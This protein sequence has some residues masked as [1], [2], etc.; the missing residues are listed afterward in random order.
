[1]DFCKALKSA[2]KK[3][4][5]IKR[6]SGKKKVVIVLDDEKTDFYMLFSC[7]CGRGLNLSFEDYT[8]DDW[9]TGILNNKEKETI[10]LVKTECSWH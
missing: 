6:T 10:Q 4:G 9:E 2:D 1:M 8:A 3:H 5:Y 7:G